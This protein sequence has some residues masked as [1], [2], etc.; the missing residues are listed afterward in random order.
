MEKIIVKIYVKNNK[1][2]ISI[3]EL[4]SEELLDELLNTLN[5]NN[6]FIR[7]YQLILNRDLF[8]RAEIIYK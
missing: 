3:M 2:P 7:Y 6:K 4:D 5:A 1:R 8:E